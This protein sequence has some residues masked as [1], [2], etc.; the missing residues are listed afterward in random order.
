MSTDNHSSIPQKIWSFLKGILLFIKKR[1]YHI[2]LLALST[3]YL[4]RNHFKIEKLDDF[5]LISTVFIIWVVLLLLPLFSELEFLGV[6]IKRE[7]QQ[8]VEKSN[9]EIKGNIRDIQAQITQL[10]ISNNIA[11]QVTVNGGPLPSETKI[12]ELIAEVHALSEANKDKKE[13]DT[14]EKAAPEQ[15]I[16]LFEMR[17]GIET[18]LKDICEKYG[19]VGKYS[20]TVVQMASYLRKEEILDSN[21]AELLIQV[22][23]ITNRGVHGEIVNQKYMDFASQ[24]YPQIMKELNELQNE[25]KTGKMRKVNLMDF[26]YYSS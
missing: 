18:A 19:I 16:K 11:N 14:A 5:S 2:I 4:L 10:Q 21:I 15:S 12:D 20:M 3:G 7:V 13:T 26:E 9:E 17:L 8:E 1:W 6:K 25:C 22:V 23:R 24:A